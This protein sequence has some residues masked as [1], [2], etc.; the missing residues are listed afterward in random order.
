MC[1]LFALS[2]ATNY[3]APRSLP[4]FAA[5]AGRNLDGWGIG[6]FRKNRAYVE[7]SAD[8]AYHEGRFHDSFQR[9]AR[10]VSSKFIVAHV[11]LR[12]SGPI[13][14]CHAHP[15]ILQFREQD[16]IFA[17]NGKAPAIEAYRSDKFR[18]EDAVSDSARTFE[19]LLDG[20]AA[21]D[22][23]SGDAPSLFRAV[24]DTSRRLVEEYPGN[25]NYLL[26]NG[27]VLFAFSN[28][29]QFLLL[30]GSKQLEGGLLLTTLEHGLSEESWTR[31]AKEKESAGVLMAILGS[32]ILL[33]ENL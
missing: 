22:T 31:F 8:R 7:K 1:D 21:R 25:Y 33:K 6:F 10:V 4:I 24:A 20:I 5:K 14:E 15:F 26:T 23:E 29:R 16:W 30:K 27:S 32:D 17:H 28:H 12:T 2:A 13:D 19:Y 3:S 18:L 11:R 9:L